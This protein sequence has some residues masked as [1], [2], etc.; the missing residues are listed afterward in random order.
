MKN[1]SVDPRTHL[2]EHGIRPSVQRL[3]IMEY[4]LTHRTHPTV[5]EIYEALHPQMPTLSRTTVYNTLDLLAA[6]GAVQHI[7]IDPRMSHYDGDV[8]LHGHF[9]CIEC[10]KIIDIPLDSL[11]EELYPE[12]YEVSSVHVYYQGNCPACRENA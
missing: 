6:K 12:G 1:P 11:P 8:S 7:T 10:K 4:L 2:L 3:E 9:L 5:E